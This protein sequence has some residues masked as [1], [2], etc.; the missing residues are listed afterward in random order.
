V[1][2]SGRTSCRSGV[3]ETSRCCGVDCVFLSCFDHDVL[4]FAGLL[5]CGGIRLHRADTLEVADFLLLTTSATV[6]FVDTVFLDGSWEEA[7]A[8]VHE[9]HALVATIIC[10]D[11]LD[12]EFVR[13]SADHGA[14]NVLWKP[15]GLDTLRSSIWTAHEITLERRLWFATRKLQERTSPNA[16]EL[17]SDLAK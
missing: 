1:R 16:S 2:S 3:A 12:R 14:S 9:R 7:L 17:C 11:S 13:T 5:G 4:F 15:L 6:F 8:M 10:A